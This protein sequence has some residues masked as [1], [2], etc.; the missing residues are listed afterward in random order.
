M[1]HTTN[2]GHE[3]CDKNM[4]GFLTKGLW[5]PSSPNL[6]PMDFAVWCILES[7]AC[8]SYYPSVTSLKAKLK[9][10]MDEISLETIRTSWN[11]ITDGLRRVV[12]A[13]GVYIEK[14][15]LSHFYIAMYN[16][17]C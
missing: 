15:I 3:W 8:S 2:I 12:E 11:K 17:L 14:Y 4:A 10:F 5:P 6:N 9:H 13:K 7:N 1:S 16:Y